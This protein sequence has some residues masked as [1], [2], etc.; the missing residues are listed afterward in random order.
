MSLKRHGVHKLTRK[1]IM[2]YVWDDI[3]SQYVLLQRKKFSDIIDELNNKIAGSRIISFRETE[4]ILG[5]E[6]I[7]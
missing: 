2:K 6:E 3:H 4:Y 5:L 1:I 7:I